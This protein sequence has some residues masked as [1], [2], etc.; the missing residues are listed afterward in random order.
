MRGRGRGRGREGGR[1]R[2]RGRGRGDAHQ[3]RR[4][5]SRVVA[6]Q[7]DATLC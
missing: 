5:T 4:E 6:S 7:A 2:G 3:D 1:G